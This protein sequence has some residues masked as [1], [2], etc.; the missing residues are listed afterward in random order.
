MQQDSRED[1]L[2]SMEDQFPLKRPRFQAFVGQVAFSDISDP[3]FPV[4]SNA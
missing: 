4:S 2:D 3:G 1:L